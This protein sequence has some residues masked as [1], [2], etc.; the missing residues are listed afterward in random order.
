MIWRQRRSEFVF[1]S[2]VST[3]TE[4]EKTELEAINKKHE[5]EFFMKQYFRCCMIDG[6]VDVGI[7]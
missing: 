2:F 7:N 5:E 4:E 1:K 3:L 6:L